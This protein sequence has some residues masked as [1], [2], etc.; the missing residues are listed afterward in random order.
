[1]CRLT[2]LLV[3]LTVAWATVAVASEQ[4]ERLY[5]RGLVE[6]HAGRV[7]Q[8]LELFDQAVGADP[9]DGYARYYRGVTHGRLENFAT[10][11]SDL[12][13]ALSR[14]PNLDQGALELGF[15]LVKMEQYQEAVKW[16]QQAQGAEQL[17]GQAS[18][19][20][21]LAQLRL[22]R[23]DAA[24][25]NFQRAAAREPELALPA[26]FYLGVAGYQSG[27]WTDAEQHFSYVEATSPDSEMGRE[28]VAFVKRIREGGVTAAA[29]SYELHGALGFQY[30][31][32]VVLAP[33]DE[34]VK[35]ALGISD[36][37]DGRVTFLLG[38]TY[39][40]W[41][42]QRV[43]LSL[44][45]DFFQSLH[46][47]LDEFNIQ[48]HRPAIQ[49]VVNPGPLRIGVRGQYDYY[50]LDSGSFLQQATALPWVS[51]PEGQYGRTELYYRMRRRDFFQRDFR[52]RDAFNHATGVRQF[53]YLGSPERYVSLGYRFDRE[54]PV[55]D[56][57]DTNAFA[58]DGH[59]VDA[60]VGWM[61][62]WSVGAEADY[63]YRSEDYARQ[64][65][66]RNDTEH[67][68]TLV[69]RKW[70]NDYLGVSAGYFAV[71]NDSN[72]TDFEYNRHV[73]SIALEV[74][75]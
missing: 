8:A 37:A 63:A 12:R 43:E 50:F 65:Q 74:R 26:R 52:I 60:G 23:T 13:E 24:R 70:L 27:D 51:V 29:R 54:D 4:S 59:Q 9:E 14:K 66:G 55:R 72:K 46:F 47:D 18:L 58:Y 15:A 25:A 7:Q 17:E 22:G 2:V 57:L 44:G 41:R 56:A 48:D 35:D 73:G 42:T 20:L 31:S 16:L 32:N 6:F 61:L 19:F 69:A 68:I 28:A 64:S 1:M 21:G 11:V 45:Y 10:A 3:G 40:P 67:R 75:Y 34:A 53:L 5:S 71:I 30:D 62:P 38:G 36:E 49:V 39:A 33:S